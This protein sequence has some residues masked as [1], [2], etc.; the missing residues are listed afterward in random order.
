MNV[1][2]SFQF[3]AL[4]WMLIHLSQERGQLERPPRVK[5]MAETAHSRRYYGF[6]MVMTVTTVLVAAGLFFLFRNGMGQ[7]FD[8]AFDRAYYIAVLSVLGFCRAPS[9]SLLLGSSS[10]RQLGCRISG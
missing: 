6:A 3:L 4:T 5:A 1:W 9:A 7:A 8:L 2:H 10:R